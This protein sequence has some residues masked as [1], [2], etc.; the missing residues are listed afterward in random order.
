MLNK[1]EINDFYRERLHEHGASAEGVGWRD[2]S[3]QEIRFRQ[4]LKV[5]DTDKPFTINDLGCGT[6]D[7]IKLLDSWYREQYTY[8]GYDTLDEM[9]F[10][11]RQQF[12]KSKSAEF[13]LLT[14]YKQLTPKDYSV[15]SGIFNVRNSISNDEWQAYIMKTIHALNDCS[16]KGFAFN[17]LT[18]YS[19]ADKMRP[20][21]YYSDPLFLFDY[22]K[23]N[24]SKNVALFHD[25]TIYDFTIV[26]RK[27]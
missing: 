9:V 6:G 14:D 2:Q 3:A 13:H 4:L 20:E 19:D 16:E 26:V 18:K 5:I 1:S 10:L 12:K 11:A 25:Y 24:F 7:L 21:L 17:A 15:A 8:T 23:K 22:C 27:S